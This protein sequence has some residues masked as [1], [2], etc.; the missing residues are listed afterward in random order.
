MNARLERQLRAA[1][2]H[3]SERRESKGGSYRQAAYAIAMERVLEA[4]RLRRA[5]HDGQGAPR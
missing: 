2:G 3:H 1:W 5:G 4:F